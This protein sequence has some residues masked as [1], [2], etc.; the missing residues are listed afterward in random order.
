MIIASERWFLV[1][2]F[3]FCLGTFV[4]A[5][6]LPGHSALPGSENR[7]KVDYSSS[8]LILADGDG[9]SDAAGRVDAIVGGLESELN[10]HTLLQYAQFDAEPREKHEANE[11]HSGVQYVALPMRTPL[12]DALLLGMDVLQ[13][14][15]PGK[16]HAI[17]V[18]LC[19]ESRTSWI[20]A[21][22]IAKQAQ[23]SETE[24]Y[25][26]N[27]AELKSEPRPGLFRRFWR[28]VGSASSWL[29]DGLL[30]E[31]QITQ[32]RTSR[33]LELV[34]AASG[35][36]SCSATDEAHALDSAMRIAARIRGRK[37]R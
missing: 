24:V 1:R 26:I 29:I 21:E 34:C 16:R 37:S 32:A 18:V 25:S 2:Y 28:P 22:R 20:S 11:P 7:P 35:G 33:M 23:Q 19:D 36:F 4:I 13:S 8:V 6:E 17:V 30:D 5:F 10:L 15:A 14:G 12:R 31:P 3:S 9:G 27:F